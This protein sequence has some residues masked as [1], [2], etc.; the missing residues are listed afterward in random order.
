[1]DIIEFFFSGL[2]FSSENG[3]TDRQVNTLLINL[4]ELNIIF[5]ISAQHNTAARRRQV[6]QSQPCNAAVGPRRQSRVP[7]S[8]RAHAAA[9]CRP[10]RPRQCRRDDVAARGAHLRQDQEWTGATPY[11]LTGTVRR[12]AGCEESVY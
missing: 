12:M 5:S 11:G 9:L 4:I 3:H 7:H 2:L 8:G 6:G 10:L 1:M